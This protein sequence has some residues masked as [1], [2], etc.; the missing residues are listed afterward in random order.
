MKQDDLKVWSILIK[1][2]CVLMISILQI[3]EF[4][5]YL[6]T[7]GQRCLQQ[8]S[9]YITLKCS[10]ERIFLQ[11]S[12]RRSKHVLGPVILFLMDIYSITEKTACN[13]HFTA[14]HPLL[15]FKYHKPVCNQQNISF[16]F[17]LSI[18]RAT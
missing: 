1:K 15:M 18:L 11:I 12:Y 8:L 10:S 16:L 3:S 2:I 14:V 6:K 4:A 17:T 7:L 13:K 9:E 5:R